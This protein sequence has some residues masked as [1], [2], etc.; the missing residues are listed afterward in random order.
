MKNP[1]FISLN[2]FRY[3]LNSCHPETGEF[4]PN[5][6]LSEPGKGRFFNHPIP[7][8]APSCETPDMVEIWLDRL[9]SYKQVE[10]RRGL[11]KAGKSNGI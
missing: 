7:P 11:L 3:G 10:P 9:S 6:R 2:T 4:L 5:P 1:V 8:F